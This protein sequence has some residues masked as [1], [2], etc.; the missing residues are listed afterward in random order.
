MESK[1]GNNNIEND[2]KI[3]GRKTTA[4][5]K[6]NNE[7]ISSDNVFSSPVIIKR[8]NSEVFE[9]NEDKDYCCC[10]VKIS[11]HIKGTVK[12]DKTKFKFCVNPEK[13]N[14]ENDLCYDNDRNMCFGASIEKSPNDKNIYKL[15]IK[16]EDII[17]VA[18]R[19][20]FYRDSGLEIFTQK[21]KSYY[22][23]FLTED[24]RDYALKVILN[25]IKDYIEICN[26]LKEIQG[27]KTENIIAYQNNTAATMGK[28]KLNCKKMKL[29][30][31]INNWK[32]W[33][34]S[35]FN[36]IMLLNIFS[37]R[38]YNDIFQY[39]VFPWI[40]ADY[41][42]PLLK[43]QKHEKSKNSKN[44]TE[45]NEEYFDYVYRDL[46]TPIGLLSINEQSEKRKQQ[47]ISGY[48]QRMQGD[49]PNYVFGCIYSNSVFVSNYLLRLFP[50]TLVAIEVNGDG[51]DSPNRLFNNIERTFLSV[52]TQTSD[53][54][55]LVPELFYLPE[56]LDNINNFAV[57][58]QKRLEN[59]VTPC[60]NN[61]YSFIITLK[62]NL[63]R[64]KVSINLNEWIDL[65]FGYKSKGEEAE[66]IYN[67]YY[68]TTYQE[69]ININKIEDKLTFLRRYEFGLVPNQL[70]N[71]KEFPKRDKLEDIKKHRNIADNN[72]KFIEAKNLPFDNFHDKDNLVL[73]CLL[74]SF[75]D[76]L[77]LVY[78][79]NYI[80]EESLSNSMFSSDYNFET[81]SK[82]HIPLMNK[83]IDYV[84]PRQTKK[85]IRPI[86]GGKIIIIGGFYDGK[87][88]IIIHEGIS[89]KIKEIYP[90][91][92]N[93]PITSLAVDREE[94]FLML[95]NDIGN[96]SI[97]K[98]VSDNPDEWKF[99]KFVNN[100]IKMINS[101]DVNSILNVWA[102]ASCDGYIFIHR[103]P[104]CKITNSIK[105]DS[106]NTCSYVLLCDSPL[107]SFLAI[108]KEEVYYYS[109][110]GHLIYKKDEVSEII[111]PTIIRNAYQDNYLVYL[112][113]NKYI[114]IRDVTDFSISN[115]VESVKNIHHFCIDLNL[116]HIYTANKN[117]SSIGV[118]SLVSS[119][120]N[121]DTNLSMSM[122][123][124]KK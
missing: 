42:E 11:H 19:K 118:I 78:N 64:N 85:Y 106:K 59:V 58:K 71:M 86:F 111:N 12:L 49:D 31:I 54:R 60:D 104:N 121:T 68:E 16:Y 115:M 61:H 1:D 9:I 20:Y 96:V 15:H 89:N 66:K 57:S 77:I 113:K 18:K 99:I 82:N 41:K 90:F 80:I 72:L 69:D 94:E 7:Q 36:L 124:T 98:I 39:P 108:F 37:N 35:N 45:E 103:L 13:N 47:Y 28:K 23:F 21:N 97:Y 95:A 62:K 4:K 56:L 76:K 38:S 27:S 88:M 40:F 26:D 51:F 109:I 17:S 10:W 110:N 25:N 84:S 44:K 5:T 50:H 14:G 6:E 67:V 22:F 100:Q 92:D 48:K 120:K 123:R 65:I 29:S 102:S 91:S 3:S 52:T 63:E 116:K 43:P 30:E 122:S 114:Y 32:N 107:P 112:V 93:S 70:S 2:D 79:R 53:V 75:P 83:I 105:I 34:I 55:E 46:G 87:I 119:K 117:G 74:Y 101:I 81:V 33:D 73:N 8:I 24:G